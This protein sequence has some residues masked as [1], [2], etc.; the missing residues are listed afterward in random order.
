MFDAPPATSTL[1]HAQIELQVTMSIPVHN[2]EGVA[3]R[4]HRAPIGTPLP[5]RPSFDIRLLPDGYHIH[6]E[7][8]GVSQENVHLTFVDYR[9]LMI[10]G[11][12]SRGYD[13]VPEGFQPDRSINGD[14]TYLLS[15]KDL[16]EYMGIRR[17]KVSDEVETK[18]PDHS[19]AEFRL[20]LRGTSSKQDPPKDP[21]KENHPGPAKPPIE[22]TPASE[23]GESTKWLLAERETGYFSRMFVFRKPILKDAAQ[24]TLQNG[25]LGVFLPLAAVLGDSAQVSLRVT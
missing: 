3:D 25:I 15:A 13:D 4:I 19:D 23:N 18:S 9:T 24:A 10:Y 17:D 11:N 8:P 14:D 1:H 20:P 22:P 6:G 7:L 16:L 12:F 5:I 21:V 2:V